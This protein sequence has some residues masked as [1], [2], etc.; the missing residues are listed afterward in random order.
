MKRHKIVRWFKVAFAALCASQ[1]IRVTYDEK[2]E[3]D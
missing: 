2:R 1:G 3:D